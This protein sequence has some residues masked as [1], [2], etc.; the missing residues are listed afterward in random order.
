VE[1]RVGDFVQGIEAVS[2]DIQKLWD[3]V[4][5]QQQ[6]IAGGVAKLMAR[7]IVADPT[8]IAY[9]FTGS[10]QG[11]ETR[12]NLANSLGSF[13]TDFAD[14][15]A[16]IS[17][18]LKNV[19]PT[20]IIIKKVIV[21]AD[22]GGDVKEAKKQCQQASDEFKKIKDDME[23]TSGTF[24]KT[25]TD[26]GSVADSFEKDRSTP[27]EVRKPNSAEPKKP[28]PTEEQKPKPEEPKPEVK[29]P[30]KEEEPKPDVKN[31]P[32][33]EEPKPEVK[34]PPKDGPK[35]TPK[36]KIFYIFNR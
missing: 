9:D 14:I 6:A 17:Q 5:N 25:A 31:P 1:K 35:M 20:V 34:N 29:T 11:N 27:K 36:G 10:L 32:K 28:K 12:T 4:K 15:I 2:Q 33:S 21:I 19:Q 13:A 18:I 8:P 23:D 22:N 24:K 7:D 26:F 3:S 16:Q 30:P